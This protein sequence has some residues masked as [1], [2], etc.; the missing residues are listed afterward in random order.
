MVH[1]SSFRFCTLWH[2]SRTMNFDPFQSEPRF[3]EPI[4]GL[5]PSKNDQFPHSNVSPYECGR[6]EMANV[7]QLIWCTFLSCIPQYKWMWIWLYVYSNCRYH[8][9]RVEILQVHNMM[10]RLSSCKGMDPNILCNIIMN[11]FHFIT[12]PGSWTDCCKRC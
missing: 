5:F 3:N 2:I 11:F 7:S 10:V 1:G 8:A 9:K 12:L 6:T 4:A